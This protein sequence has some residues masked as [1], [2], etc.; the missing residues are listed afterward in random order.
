MAGENILADVVA[1]G[2][3]AMGYDDYQ[4]PNEPDSYPNDDSPDLPSEDP[5][6]Y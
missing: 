3:R 6:E 1:K 2:A 4:Y 5:N